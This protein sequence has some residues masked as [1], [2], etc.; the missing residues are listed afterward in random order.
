MSNRQVGYIAA[1]ELNCELGINRG[2]CERHG[3]DK[4][5][6]IIGG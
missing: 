1:R 4:G 2:I 3:R 6:G 5:A